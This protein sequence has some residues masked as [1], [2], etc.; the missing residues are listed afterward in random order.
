MSV[1]D[2]ADFTVVGAFEIH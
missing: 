1:N 2:E